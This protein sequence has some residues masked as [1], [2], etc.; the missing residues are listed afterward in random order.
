MSYLDKKIEDYTPK[1]ASTKLPKPKAWGYGHYQFPY[2]DD[3]PADMYFSEIVC[4]EEVET[5]KGKKGITVFYLIANFYLAYRSI[6]KITLPTD[7]EKFYYIKQTYLYD[8]TYY[9][10]FIE[11]MYEAMDFEVDNDEEYIDVSL[12]DFVGVREAITIAYKNVNGIGSIVSRCPWS[13]QDFVDRYERSVAEEEE[14]RAAR[15][16]AEV[17]EYGNYI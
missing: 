12:N 7:V 2:V 3:V 15:L 1:K 9:T 13:K 16:A 6:N 14:L 11:A 8:S 17:D 4:V 5:T 10:D